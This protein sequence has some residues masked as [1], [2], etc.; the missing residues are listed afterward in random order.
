ME[1]HTHTHTDPCIELRYVQLIIIINSCIVVGG[2]GAPNQCYVIAY[3]VHFPDIWCCRWGLMVIVE[4][5]VTNFVK[6]LDGIFLA[7][8]SLDKQHCV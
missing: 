5:S 4:R 2:V 3:T 8:N 1:G 7:E 6:V